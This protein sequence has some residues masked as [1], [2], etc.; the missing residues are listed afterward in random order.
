MK[1]TILTA[2]MSLF[3]T[4]NLSAQEVYTNSFDQDLVEKAQQ[5]VEAGEWR[6]GFTAASPDSSVNLVEFYQQYQKNPEQWKAL[7]KWL[8]ETDLLAIEKG[9]HPI[10]GTALV[11]S[12]EDS[13]NSELEKRR[14]ESHYH[15]IDFQYVVKGI[16]RF[17]VLEHNSSTPNCEY[18]PDVIH[19]DYDVAK[20]RFFDSTTDKF[21][22]FFPCDWHIAKINNDT[23]DQVIRVI[24]IK[25]DYVE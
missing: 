12:V 6:N 7:F 22:I 1:T 13:N 17:A 23:D 14:S 10:E 2:I 24:V 4:A 25:V 15:H 9:K 5:W 19:Y 11:V 18:Q 21:I 8:S 16:E 20:A 3:L